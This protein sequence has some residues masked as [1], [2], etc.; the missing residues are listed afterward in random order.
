M[1]MTPLPGRFARIMPKAM[2]SRIRGSNSLTMARYSKKQPTAIM[3]A[4]R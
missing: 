1:W 3:I 2:G 4:Y